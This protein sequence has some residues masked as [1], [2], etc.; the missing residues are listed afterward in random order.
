M[1]VTVYRCLVQHSVDASKMKLNYYF[2][3]IYQASDSVR[4]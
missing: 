3:S 4:A 2:V 1:E